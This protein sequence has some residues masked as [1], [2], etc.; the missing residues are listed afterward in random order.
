MQQINLNS[1]AIKII[2]A[3]SFLT[4]KRKS[5]KKV[6]VNAFSISKVTGISWRTVDKYLQNNLNM[7][8][9]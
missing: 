7:K 6:V 8:V 2:Y 5:N 9:A 3:I 1:N 4:L